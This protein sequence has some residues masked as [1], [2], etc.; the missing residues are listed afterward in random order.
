MAA[1]APATTVDDL[2]EFAGL[3]DIAEGL[4]IVNTTPQET[5]VPSTSAAADVKKDAVPPAAAR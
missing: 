3:R 1:A 2:I 5:S 4:G